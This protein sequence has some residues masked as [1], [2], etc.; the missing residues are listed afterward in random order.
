LPSAALSYKRDGGGSIYIRWARGF[1]AGGFNPL[2]NPSVFVI[3]NVYLADQGSI[4]RGETVDTLEAGI[5][6]PFF[7]RKVQLT[8]DVF[9][10]DYK[11]E[12]TLAHARPAYALSVVQ[13]IINA[14][15]A[16]SYGIEGNLDWQ[17]TPSFT[18]SASAGYLKA[19]YKTFKNSGSAI[20]S[21]FDLSGSKLN[22]APELQASV[23]ANL[24][25]P[26]T[27]DL[28]LAATVLASSTSSV[29]YQVS[30]TRTDNTT[31]GPLPD[32]VG[33]PYV[34]VNARIGL[35]PPDGRWKVSLYANNLFNQA[36][37]TYGASNAGNTTQFT[38]GNPRIVGIEGAFRF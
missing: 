27:R 15:G 37:V 18:L 29:L 2:V 33:N 35:K 7:N 3:N 34:L 9:Y 6:R 4:F 12:Q 13:A 11:N 22:N 30:G 31:S 21:A 8:T 20:L 36:Y 10:N 17:V 32:A 1:K 28:N 16:R 19:T 14:N 25:T 38:S 24:D 26:I 5:K 23:T